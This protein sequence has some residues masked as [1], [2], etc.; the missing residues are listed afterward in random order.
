MYE[1]AS[2]IPRIAVP[3]QVIVPCISFDDLIDPNKMQDDRI[4]DHWDRPAYSVL[5]SK[6]VDPHAQPHPKQIYGYGRRSLASL[7]SLFHS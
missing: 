6:K 2:E 7:A 1:A 3:A 4:T 5:R